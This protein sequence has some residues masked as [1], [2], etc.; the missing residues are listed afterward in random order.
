MQAISL[1][2]N[3]HAA[4]F[5]A[6]PELFALLATLLWPL[7]TGFASYF[8]AQIAAR[9]PKLAA[10]LDAS[11]FNAKLSLRI[12]WRALSKK[13][14]LPPMSIFLALLLL[15]CG[16]I[17]PRDAAVNGINMST[18]VAAQGEPQL[19]KL[20]RAEQKACESLPAPASPADCVA[21]VRKR[22]APAW[23]AYVAFL[24]ARLAA[25]TL[26]NTYDASAGVSTPP[27]PEQIAKVVAT[28]AAAAGAFS[29]AVANVQGSTL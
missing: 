3:G 25:V 11:G 20:D 16:P 22:Y 9:A 14:P 19:A 29:T 18:T 10:F 24:A 8:D 5:A 7:L 6:H 12:L 27:T 13:L 4:Y 17:T 2:F 28:L 15:G 26:I 23:K 21:D 1:W